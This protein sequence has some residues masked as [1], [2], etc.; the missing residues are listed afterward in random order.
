MQDA[1]ATPTEPV[2][3][4]LRNPVTPL[5]KGMGY[6]R[7]YRYDHAF[8]EHHAGQAHLPDKLA[9]RRYYN[10][11]ELGYEQ[12]IREWLAKLRKQP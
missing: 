1:Q 9:N 8:P 10:P 5:M 6:G 12:R 4:H 3:L 11:G 7:D 2:P